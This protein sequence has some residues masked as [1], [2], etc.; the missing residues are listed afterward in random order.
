MSGM[1]VIAND[2]VNAR[3]IAETLLG[4][5]GLSVQGAGDAVELRDLLHFHEVT[6]VVLDVN[7]PGI[8][9]LDFFRRVPHGAGPR[10]PPN[11]PR[12]VLVSNRN[13]VESERFVRQLGAEVLLRK[14]VPPRQF[15]DAVER[16]A[17]PAA[18]EAA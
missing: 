15:V 11:G 5:R 12:L 9:G 1:I 13:Q 3:I 7:L 16:L 10:R 2:D 14:P 6:V 17:E 18:P 8:S 4:L